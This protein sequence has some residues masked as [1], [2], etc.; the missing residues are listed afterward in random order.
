MTRSHACHS[1][2]LRSIVEYPPTALV[3]SCR[4]AESGRPLQAQGE[5]R[6]CRVQ[7]SERPDPHREGPDYGAP[8][9]RCR[10]HLQPLLPHGL[11]EARLHRIRGML[12]VSREESCIAPCRQ[13]ISRL[14]THFF[15]YIIGEETGG[16][17]EGELIV[18]L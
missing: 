8:A 3:L 6:H 17:G 12:L 10:K 9:V 4:I 2:S 18:E 13:E 14:P 11:L 5:I 1:L 7:R 16:G 15:Q